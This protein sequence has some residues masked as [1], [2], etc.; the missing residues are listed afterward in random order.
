M[1]APKK[2]RTVPPQPEPAP[3]GFSLSSRHLLAALLLCATA[4]L[5][6][7]NSFDAGFVL[8]SK[9]LLLQDPRIRQATAANI[10]QI[11]QHTYWWPTGEAGLYRPLTTLSYLG[12]YAIWGNR[13][14][15]AGYH[16]I[17]FLLHAGNILLVY[18]LATRLIGRFWP[19]VFLTG[20]WA[21]HPLLTES[22]TNMVGRPDLLAA[23]AVLGGLTLYLKS[24]ESSGG[25]RQAWLLGLA[26]AGAAGFFSKES[27]V[28]LVGVVALFELTWW[29]ERKQVRGLLLAG[30]ALLPPLGLMLYQRSAVLGASPKADFPFTDNPLIGA[31]FW[32]GKLT[33]LK[34]IA[35]YLWLTVWPLKLSA[36]YS[37]SQIRIA[38]GT[39]QDWLAWITVAA[40]AAGV[41]CLYRVHRPAFFLACFAFVTLLPGSN[42]LFPIGTIMAERFM[43]LPSIGLLGCLVAGIYAAGERMGNRWFAPVLLSLIATG[44]TARTWAR[45]LDW[46]DD[47]SLGMATVR[48]APESFKAHKILAVAL[49]E[50]D[51]GHTQID[52]EL[53]EARQSMS[54]IDSLPDFRSDPAIYRLA[55]TLYLKKGDDLRSRNSPGSTQAYQSA[56]GA[57]RRSVAILQTIQRQDPD[58]G[59]PVPEFVNAQTGRL[60]SM[61]Y[62]RL[63]DTEKALDVAIQARLVEPLNPE[64]Y[65]QVADAFLAAGRTED[66]ATALL[67]GMIVTQDMGLRQELVS[68]YRNRI[69]PKGCALVPGPNGPA[70][71]PSCGIIHEHLCAIAAD[72]IKIRLATGRRDIAEQLK[73]SFLHDYGCPA[74]PINAVLPE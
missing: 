47:V 33:A 3:P 64:L 70:I 45:N 53:S 52:R 68:L 59:Q 27:A 63:G 13:E 65:R 71:N 34:V 49:M 24:T 6:F 7:S 31:G 2:R 20:L 61:A 74:G 5:A 66:A 41:L 62:E 28:V 57:L 43:Y 14:D 54:L 32:A 11:F 26:M 21:V 40:A 30:L 35:H 17:N 4:L 12:N 58:A 72:S 38:S 73:R 69:D 16:W 67:E 46:H 18:A 44:F 37:Y 8:D 15:P 36:D 55:A 19:A 22:V 50:S 9:P 60:L 56:L 29:R 23:M 42:L 10:A 51:P 1:R 39:V 25:R 48:S